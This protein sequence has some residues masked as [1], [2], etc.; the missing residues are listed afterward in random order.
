MIP[1]ELSE[2]SKVWTDQ[3]FLMLGAGK[4]G[5]SAFWAE[6]GKK[7]LFF[8]CEPS[9]SHLKLMKVP[10]RSWEDLRA[11]YGE[12]IAMKDDFPFD[13]IVLDTVDRVVS[14]AD[15]ET[16]ECTRAKFAKSIAQGKIEINGVGD[17]PNGA[18]WFMSTK[19]V[20]NF[21]MK[22]ADLPCALVMVSH[23]QNIEI[24]E[25]SRKYHKDTI[26]IGGKTGRGLLYFTDHTIQV[27]SRY[28]GTELQRYLV[29]RPS[30][31][32]EAG[33][34]GEVLPENMA[35]NGDMS[36]NYEEFRKL[37]T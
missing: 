5:K 30:D 3:K 34:R 9:L 26:S 21:L 16:I 25:P 23:V 33:S 29:T 2:P 37:F 6:G 15:E 14:Y 7:T 8:E 28:V 20:D 10:C 32:M 36:T 1:T 13:T 35:W 27:K 4:I 18:G 19:L 17:V 31:S 11:A 22:M 12:L 24:T